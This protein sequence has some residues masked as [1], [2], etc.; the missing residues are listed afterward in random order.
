MGII[1][2]SRDLG[3]PA[4]TAFS[5]VIGFFTN[6][7]MSAQGGL[8]IYPFINEDLTSLNAPLGLT[9]AYN[10]SWKLNIQ[11]QTSIPSSISAYP[12][13]PPRRYTGVLTFLGGSGVDRYE[14]INYTNQTFTAGLMFQTNLREAPTHGAAF[15]YPNFATPT[16][17]AG[18]GSGRTQ[19][20]QT[21]FLSGN[22]R[23]V[24]TVNWFLFPDITYAAVILYKAE[25]TYQFQTGSSARVF[26]I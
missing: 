13:N 21:T 23:Y 12:G 11:L 15:D 8:N 9:W 24:D 17:N 19:I 22:E 6:I 20:G 25:I 1:S 18:I 5:N 4:S 26:P 3:V 10:V 16:T 14:Q 2:A 7:S